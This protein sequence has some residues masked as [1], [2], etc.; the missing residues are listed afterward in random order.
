MTKIIYKYFKK[1]R[2]EICYIDK[3]IIKNKNNDINSENKEINNINIDANVIKANI[4]DFSLEHNK[5][6]ND[7]YKNK[8]YFH[9]DKDYQESIDDINLSFSIDDVN[10]FKFKDNTI[11]A[12]FNELN[13]ANNDSEVKVTFGQDNINNNN[14]TNNC[15]NFEI[16]TEGRIINDSFN[17]SKNNKIPKIPK[18]S[19]TYKRDEIIQNIDKKCERISSVII[20]DNEEEN[21]DIKINLDINR[22]N[23]FDNEDKEENYENESFRNDGCLLLDIKPNEEGNLKLKIDKVNIDINDNMDLNSDRLYIK[24]IKK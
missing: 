12:V 13:N 1:L 15:N 11:E 3:I 21:E 20:Y 7:I 6:N 2:N 8:Y 24:I 19:R 9:Q 23:I 4:L 16:S 14:N 18:V 10:T 17:E 5:D 22:D